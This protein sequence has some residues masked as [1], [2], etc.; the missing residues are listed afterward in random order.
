MGQSDTPSLTK[1]SAAEQSTTHFLALKER[2]RLPLIVAPMFLV[3][4]PDLMVAVCCAGVAGSFPTV[5][6]RNED[7]LD[8]WLT[9][10]NSSL[11]EYEQSTGQAATPVCPNLIVHKSNTRMARDLAVLI[12]HRPAAVITSVGAPPDAALSALHDVGTLVFTDVATIRHAH[13][14]VE[15]RVDGLI[16]L[17][18]GSGGQTGHLNPFAFV[19]AVREF[20][21]GPLVLAGGISDGNA[22]RAATV[23]GCD[24][25]YAGTAFITARESMASDAYRD[26]LVKSS[27]D[28]I[29]QTMAFTGVAANFLKPSLISAGIEP[30][31]L[32]AKRK[33]NISE[34]INPNSRESPFNCWKDLWSAGHSVSGVKVIAPAADIVARFATEYAMQPAGYP[35]TAATTICAGSTT[36][37]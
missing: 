21:D 17:S 3:S 18:A 25:A 4:G 10:I 11:T 5:N 23:L 1:S 15:A 34:D 29:L 32:I 19:R 2:M 26:M 24:L 37:P 27:A 14:A 30:D 36:R 33:I 13:K 9:N 16:L 20:Y 28:D 12:K 7:E 22:L 35:S 31:R 6:C 8:T